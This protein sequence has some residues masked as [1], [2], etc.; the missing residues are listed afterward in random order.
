MSTSDHIRLAKVTQLAELL[1]TSASV[2]SVWTHGGRFA[3]RHLDVAVAL[4]IPK[5][6]LV[7]GIEARRQDAQLARE[8]QGELNQFLKNRHQEKE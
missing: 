7:A 1:G 5:Q 3:E 4:G 2:V 6:V 8:C